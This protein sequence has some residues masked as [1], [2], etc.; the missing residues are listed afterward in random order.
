MLQLKKI[1]GSRQKNSYLVIRQEIEDKTITNYQERRLSERLLRI[2]NYKIS[3]W[4]VF[5]TLLTLL[6]GCAST[7]QSQAPT[8]QAPSVKTKSYQPDLL[9]NSSKPV[10]T[11]SLQNLDSRLYQQLQNL[12][13]N[14]Q[15]ARKDGYVYTVDV[16]QILVYAA[17]KKDLRLY[18][19]LR[20]FAIRNLIV[21]K[22]SDPYTKGFVLWR[23]QPGSPPDASGTTEAL[24][25]AESLWLGSQVF[26]DSRDRDRAMLLLQG[27]ARHQQ[28]DHNVWLIRN[29][30]NLQTR[31]FAN[32]SFLVG[33]D[34]DLI[35]NIAEATGDPTL[36]PLAQKSY[37][38]VRQAVTPSGLL[39][40]IIQPEVL[41]L[42]PD[43]KHLV[44]FSPNDV[45][46]LA[47]TCTVA[48][49]VTTGAPEIGQKVIRFA[50]QRL[51][52]LSTYY[53]GR[54]GEPA[55]QQNAEVPTYACLV[56]LAVKLGDRKA[57]NAFLAPF[58]T[59]AEAVIKNTEEFSLYTVIEALL[60]LQSVLEQST[61]PPPT[62]QN[63]VKNVTFNLA[64][65]QDRA[66]SRGGFN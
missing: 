60:A 22:P 37:A 3:L 33:Y 28:I 4:A 13:A 24:R 26:G 14:N 6:S 5:L 56:R 23:Y 40:D 48:E 12:I 30:F 31:A 17:L 10:D 18:I 9:A 21:D 44:I 20:D 63:K 2:T 39:Y 34:P 27:Y 52:K 49:R 62:P 47:N 15:G 46:K 55:I 45:V 7:K 50:M 16:S 53:Y 25:L 58:V 66:F 11:A 42:M 36:Q 19:P 64:R 59:H 35:E 43:L 38:I 51:P 41:T 57:V 32:N 1:F 61:S 8:I 29:Y 65:L 54:T